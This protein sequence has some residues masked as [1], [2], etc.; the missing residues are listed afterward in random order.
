MQDVPA[1]LTPQRIPAERFSDAEAALARLAL[2]Y[3]THTSFLREQFRAF[4][5]AG[6]LP[7]GCG[8]LTRRC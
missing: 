6:T 1:I 7:S 2:I 3:D 8:P 5:K 4:L